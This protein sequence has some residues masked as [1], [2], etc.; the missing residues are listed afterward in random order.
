MK[1]NIEN[2]NFVKENLLFKCYPEVNKFL[3]LFLKP[4]ITMLKIHGV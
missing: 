2:A 4:H 1:S 3:L